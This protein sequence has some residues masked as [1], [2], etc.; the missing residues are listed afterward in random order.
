MKT[1]FKFN[2]GAGA[3]FAFIIVFVVFL[4]T[5]GVVY[6]VINNKSK[7]PEASSMWSLSSRVYSPNN[8]EFNFQPA[9]N[10]VIALLVYRLAD[11]YVALDT[12]WTLDG[13]TSYVWNNVPSGEYKAV[14]VA[15][16]VAPVSNESIFTVA[17]IFNRCDFNKDSVINTADQ[18]LLANGWGAVSAE[19]GNSVYDLNGD[20]YV[21]SLDQGILAQAIKAFPAPTKWCY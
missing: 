7:T 19:K 15:Y 10:N 11:G 18:K 13:R 1:A 8:V 20:K 21:N 2:R 5:A 3:I 12:G 4:S 16:G 14:L 6:V 9:A 17:R